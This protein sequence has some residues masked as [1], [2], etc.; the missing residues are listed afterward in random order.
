MRPGCAPRAVGTHRPHRRCAFTQACCAP[1]TVR[2]CATD[3]HSRPGGAHRSPALT[4]RGEFRRT[5]THRQPPPNSPRSWK[6]SP[7]PS[8]TCAPIAAPHGPGR[9]GPGAHP[10]GCGALHSGAVRA[11]AVRIGGAVRSGPARRR[12]P[13]TLTA[14]SAVEGRGQ[15][16]VAETRGRGPGGGFESGGTAIPHQVLAGTGG[17]GQDPARCR[18]RPGPPGRKAAWTSWSGLL[19]APVRLW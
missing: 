18:L 4:C 17:G 11:A 16:R 9:G 10:R 15:G 1:G 7:Q 19:R 2:K 14:W 13:W 12:V 5:R 8:R 3:A 6:N